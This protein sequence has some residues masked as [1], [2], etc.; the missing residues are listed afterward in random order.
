MIK[1]KKEKREE[2][3]GKRKAKRKEGSRMKSEN[4]RGKAGTGLEQKEVL[5]RMAWGKNRPVPKQK[6]R[7][8]EIDPPTP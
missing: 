7:T 3:N 1:I 5:D 6:P 4:K 8:D 2:K